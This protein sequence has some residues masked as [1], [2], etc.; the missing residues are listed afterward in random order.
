MVVVGMLVGS[1]A[2]A[3]TVIVRS[4]P[5]AEARADDARTMTG[6]TTYL[7]EDVGSTPPGAFVVDDP[8]HL[9]GCAGDS[10]GVGLLH[11]AWTNGAR[12]WNVDYRLES[13][14]GGDT[15]I[16]RHE[17]APAGPASVNTL[18]SQLPPIDP[19]TWKPGDAP[20][21]FV[22]IHDDAGRV[23]GVTVTITTKA[24]M[25]ASMVARS[26]NPSE[27]LSEITTTS[28]VVAST[29]TTTSPTTTSTT[30]T[31]SPAAT[32]TLPAAE[33]TTTTTPAA[34]T[35][36]TTS[37]TTTT[38]PPCVVIAAV[39]DPLN[40]TNDRGK[41]KRTMAT[42]QDHVHVEV[43]TDGVCANL[44][45]EFDPDRSD[46]TYD[47]QWLSF[48]PD[49]ATRTVTIEGHPAGVQWSDGIHVLTLRNGIGTPELARIN[50]EVT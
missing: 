43:G 9:T 44:V 35:T 39:A 28:V 31:T 48:G 13:D 17:C 32:T 10:P 30:T 37:T 18:T 49:G 34:T 15:R 23:V 21:A 8:H 41:S 3:F 26:N 16:R 5:P 12:S 24:G 22:P 14:E 42:L 7:P 1:V 27:R 4:F 2:T 45:L 29:T 40:P 19:S 25:T 36:T 33:S 38:V 50:L 6:L 46:G 20:A 11:M 47:P